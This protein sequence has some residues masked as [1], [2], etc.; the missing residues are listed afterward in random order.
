MITSN[1]QMK[2]Y[3]IELR[4]NWKIQSSKKVSQTGV[5]LSLNSA[6]TEHWIPTQVPSTVLGTLTINQIYKDP[7]FGENLKQIPVEEF[8]VPWWYITS[9]NID[10]NKTKLNTS[11]DFDG[12]NYKA[13]VWLNGELIAHS[14]EINGAYRTASFDISEYIKTGKNLLAIEIIPPKPG[15]F[16]T[17]FVDWNPAPPDRNMGIIRPVKLHLYKGVKIKHPFVQSKVDLKSLNSAELKITA[18]LQNTTNNTI[19][20]SLIGQIEDIWFEKEITIKAN[21]S[22]FIEFEPSVYSQLKLENP[23]LW[24]PF[25]LGNPDLYDLKLYFEID[26]EV[27]DTDIIRFG[28][29]EIEDFWLNDIHRGYKI[30]GKKVLIKGA[31]WTDD[32]F[33]MDTDFTIEA[34][35]KY[36]RQ[37][38]LNTIRLEGIW[39]KDHKLYNLCDELG[40][41]IMVGWSCHWE[42]EIHMGVPVNE[43]FGGVYKPEDI[44]HV[45][46]AW[47][48]QV[49]W[50]RN[51]PSIFVWTVASDKVPITKLEEKYI[52]TFKKYDPTR[53]YLNS[54]GGVGSDLHIIGTE[55]VVSEISGSSGVKMLG[56]YAY[57]APVYWFTDTNFGG[58]YG[59]NTET[60]PG[61][62][63]PQLES[64]N[65][66]IPD[67]KLWP[68]ND[69]WNY[70]CGRYE[71]A[72]LS[73]FTTA[74]KERYGK[75]LNLEEF[76]IKAQAMNYE[77]M[78]PMFEAFQVNKENST[79]IIQWMLNAA[80]P[81]MYWQLY[82]YYLMPTAAFY[83]TQKACSSLH[84][85][86]NY[87]DHH[88]YAINDQYQSFKSL[89]ARI[90]IYDITSKIFID[91]IIEFDIEADASIPLYKLC[92]LENISTTY[93]VDLRIIEANNKELDVN[94][95]WLSTKE[96]ELDY[97]A[98]LGE[99]AFH[100]PSKVYSDFNMLNSIEKVDIVVDYQ[101]KELKNQQELTVTINNSSNLIAF[102]INLKL[103]DKVSEAPILPVYWEDNFISLLPQEQRVLK[104][105]FKHDSDVALKVESW[106]SKTIK[107]GE[108][109][110]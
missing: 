108:I 34:Q 1:E 17:G 83:A 67:D 35:V 68:I 72:D 106:N 64:L 58:A 99:F 47:E 104:V 5:E 40:I 88:I 105:R 77:L 74:I 82:D 39:G 87:G 18:E 19:S 37:M 102:F 27:A 49:I 84:L 16:S 71:F 14:N 22:L 24:W 33:L 38:N 61:A 80:W 11:L 25:H 96:E 44:D 7:Y 92:N 81:K 9:F 21:S 15:D 52:D 70:H 86:Y 98:N 89:K 90:R 66:F 41:L 4:D 93:F 43:R 53:P 110:D 20:G 45:A 60:G 54:T 6:I 3:K 42:H 23:R 91:Q 13:N 94:F 36:V 57:T 85:I 2:C 62:Q 31:G 109:S 79:G 32:L 46:Q 73:R 12:I 69:V 10:N 75:P 56:P 30:N 55:E 28:I 107:Y 8:E 103:Q 95:Y 59:F 97:E 51:H 29:R 78:R 76:N 101:L 65:K 63:I 50:L 48:D 100:T 26:K